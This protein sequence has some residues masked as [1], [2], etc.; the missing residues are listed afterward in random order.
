MAR[1]KISQPFEVKTT[2]RELSVSD[3]VNQLRKE[4]LKLPTIFTLTNVLETAEDLQDMIV[5][6][7]AILDM[8][9]LHEL[10]FTIEDEVVY[11]QRREHE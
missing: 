6:F 1:L 11:I 10:S 8:I 5:T 2:A 7:L 9:R 3:R 4:M